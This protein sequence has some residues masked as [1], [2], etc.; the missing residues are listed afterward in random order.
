MNYSTAIFLI[1]DA[2]RAINISYEPNCNKRRVFKTLDP[3]IKVEDFVVIPT[4]SRYK[5][6]VVKVEE[7]DLDLDIDT[8]DEIE[9]IVGVVDRAD[10]EEIE[11]QEADAIAKIKSA[12]KRRKREEL[13]KNL[14]ADAE[15][16]LKALPI[17][18]V[19]TPEAK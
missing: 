5:M 6:T 8:P 13:R 12:E 17:Y 3:N 14:L 11:A 16:D 1:S 18:S 4:G 9:W 10:F 7:V 15:D 2:V 19:G